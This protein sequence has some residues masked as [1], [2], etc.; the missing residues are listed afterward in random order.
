[1]ILYVIIAIFYITKMVTTL[2]IKYGDNTEYEA[3]TSRCTNK[4]RHVHQ[5]EYLEDKRHKK[6]KHTILASVSSLF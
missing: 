2:L 1:M 5:T 6:Q 4:H 3:F